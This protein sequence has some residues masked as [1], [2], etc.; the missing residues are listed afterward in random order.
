MEAA[1]QPEDAP[2]DCRA[3]QGPANAQYAAATSHTTVATLVDCL[4]GYNRLLKV[5]LL[6]GEILSKGQVTRPNSPT[7]SE[8]GRSLTYVRQID[9]CRFSRAQFHPGEKDT[10]VTQAHPGMP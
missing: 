5:S 1:N 4:E 6:P 3:S 10:W 7:S 8:A 2:G 9:N